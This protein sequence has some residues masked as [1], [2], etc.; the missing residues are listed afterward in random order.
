MRVSSMGGFFAA[1]AVVGWISVV[2]CSSSVMPPI[3]TNND[4]PDGAPITV[5]VTG[6]ADAGKDVS[7]VAVDASSCTLPPDGGCNDLA[8]CSGK[9]FVVGSSSTAP[10][11]TGGTIAP[12]TYNLV[13]VNAYGIAA[14]PNGTSTSLWFR[15][16]F[17]LTPPPVADAGT[18]DGGAS[19]A[20][21]V[22]A[23]SGGLLPMT[24]ASESNTQSLA[25]LSGSFYLAGTTVTIGFS[26]GGAD[27]VNG[28]YSAGAG[29]FTLYIDEPSGGT[30]AETFASN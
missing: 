13:A 6:G 8:L 30:L 1:S 21:E 20:G 19:D 3:E 14:V 12:G 2:A 15:A 5:V 16:T 7:T 4:T 28:T 17:A 9:V 11:G 18:T 10:T 22:D 27:T 25:N 26:C 24:E 23:G 29:T